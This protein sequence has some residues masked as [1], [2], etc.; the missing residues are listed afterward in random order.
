M[1]ALPLK[2]QL[3]LAACE[4][5]VYF[6]IYLCC[7]RVFSFLIFQKHRL[8]IKLLKNTLFDIIS[9]YLLAQITYK[10]TNY[11]SHTYK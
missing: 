11:Y 4:K 3:N 5:Y 9:K 8:S 10:R 2:L 6:K 7:S 1:V